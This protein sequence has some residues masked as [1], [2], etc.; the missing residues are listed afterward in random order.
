MQIT[1][2]SVHEITELDSNGFAMSISVTQD[3]VPQEIKNP[4]L[5]AGAVLKLETLDTMG[6]GTSSLST[7]SIFPVKSN[8]QIETK[9]DMAVTIAGQNQ[10]LTT[11]LTMEMNL[12]A[13][14]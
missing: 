8:L 2:T 13:G 9:E 11:E 14:K 10:K 7:T 1:Q 4:A 3:A 6:T 5:P 12:E